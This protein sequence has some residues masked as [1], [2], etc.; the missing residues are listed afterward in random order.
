MNNPT[1]PQP[2]KR[3]RQSRSQMLVESIQ[4]ACLNI[5]RDEGPD[6]LTTHRIAE[7]AGVNIASLYQY[8][9]NKEAV[10]TEIFEQEIRDY[11]QRAASRFKELAALANHSLEETLSAVIEMECDQLLLLYR[12]N[13][14]FYL[15]YQQSF[16]I[17]QRVN[18]VTLALKNPGWEEWFAGFLHRHRAKLHPGDTEQMAFMARR[19]LEGC[20]M[21]ALREQPQQLESEQFQQEL[22]ALLLSYL[23]RP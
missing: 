7:V 16:D 19:A 15:Q 20:L 2:R 8:F 17:H 4:Q 13:P 5:L 3:P 12:L 14:E 11:E 18:D 23:T 10:L 9:P 1:P 6:K 22:L 21:G